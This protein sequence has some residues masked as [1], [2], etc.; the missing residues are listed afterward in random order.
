MQIKGV[1][2]SWNDERGFGFIE[3]VRGGPEIFVHIK[4]FSRDGGDR[5]QVNQRVLFEIERGPEGKKRARNVEMV[6]FAQT[7]AHGSK[8]D[9]PAPRGM[10]TLL[11]IPAF[12]VV[13]FV[14]CFWREAP[15][16]TGLIYLV[17][18]V[19]TYLAYAK[20]KSSARHGEW[21]ISESTLHALS[22]AGGW[23]GA[24]LAQQFLRHKSAKTEFRVVFWC[25]VV[26]NVTLFIVVCSTIGGSI[27]TMIARGRP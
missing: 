17:P 26:M 20:D 9:A 8:Y 18:S 27:V 10:A 24:L 16:W 13:Y 14:A 23:P 15:V 4:A 6:Y 7:G 25:T 11:A 1:I 3:P 5:P 19:V 12:V 21:R 22:F 2:K